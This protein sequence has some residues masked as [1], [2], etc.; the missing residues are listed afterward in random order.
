MRIT[1]LEVD[2]YERLGEEV[3]SRA[4]PTEVITRREF[5]RQEH[6]VQFLVY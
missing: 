3:I 4:V 1:D 5:N 2:G 6:R